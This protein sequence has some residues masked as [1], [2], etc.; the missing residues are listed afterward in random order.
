MSAIDN[1]IVN[2]LQPYL[3]QPIWIVS[4][5]ICGIFVSLFLVFRF[6][7]KKLKS[8]KGQSTFAK[9]CLEGYSPVTVAY[10]EASNYARRKSTVSNRTGIRKQDRGTGN[11]LELCFEYEDEY[12]I[13]PM[14]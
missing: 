8:V 9:A 1:I 12:E 10:T 5:V 13:L 4:A 6:D 7:K 11:I 2:W 3:T 14:D